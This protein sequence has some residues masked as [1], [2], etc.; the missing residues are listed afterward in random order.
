MCLLEAFSNLSLIASLEEQIKVDKLL[1]KDTKKGTNPILL[2]V[3]VDGQGLT[4]L[5]MLISNYL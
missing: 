4:R 3:G 1:R 5:P 2:G